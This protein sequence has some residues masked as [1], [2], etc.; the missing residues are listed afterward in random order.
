[1][2]EINTLGYFSAKLKIYRL[3]YQSY[4]KRWH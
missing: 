2:Y 4:T 3:A 1:M